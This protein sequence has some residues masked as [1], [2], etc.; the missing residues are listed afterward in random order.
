MTFCLLNEFFVFSKESSTQRAHHLVFDLSDCR[1]D[2]NQVLARNIRL[3]NYE[4]RKHFSHC[5]LTHLIKG[6]FLAM[7][8]FGTEAHWRAT[9]EPREMS[10]SSSGIDLCSGR[11]CL[12]AVTLT[13]QP[14]CA[15]ALIF[16]WQ[17]LK[18][19]LNCGTNDGQLC[20]Y[21]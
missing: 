9:L 7:A 15:K 6:L 19:Y 3:V 8:V 14:G 2:L 1:L 10:Y 21:V 4:L 17:N 5:R 11:G 12:Q 16:E 13:C 20:E 18:C